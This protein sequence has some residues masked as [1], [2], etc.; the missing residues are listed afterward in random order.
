MTFAD[1]FGVIQDR[2]SK[3]LIGVGRV[4]GRIFLHKEFSDGQLQAHAI[5]TY[6]LWHIHLDHPSRQVISLLAKS[7][8][9]GDNFSNKLDE[10]CDICFCAKQTRCSFSE[11]DSKASEPFEIIHCDIWGVYHIPST[12]GAHYF[13]TIVDDASR[14]VWVYLMREKSELSFLQ[15]FVTYAKNQFDKNVKY[16]QSDNGNEF[17]SNPMRRFILKRGLSIKLVVWELHSKMHK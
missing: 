8:D 2:I 7:L 1:T 5:K 9:I 3:N 4:K 15:N 14:A 13:L 6:D 12:C 17:T 16:I 11:S 10:P